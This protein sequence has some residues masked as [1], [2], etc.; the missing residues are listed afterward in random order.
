V[1]LRTWEF[2]ISKSIPEEALCYCLSQRLGLILG[3]GGP[4]P[5]VL[6][7]LVQNH[8][9]AL[10]ENKIKQV[11]AFPKLGTLFWK[12]SQAILM[13]APV[14]KPCLDQPP[15]SSSDDLERG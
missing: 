1:F 13:M 8:T 5:E 9:G 3:N 12:D 6:P 10:F 15:I 11:A 4:K 7:W 2:H 14:G